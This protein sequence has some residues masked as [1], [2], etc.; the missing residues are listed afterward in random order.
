MPGIQHGAQR[1]VEGETEIVAFVDQQRWMLA[2][3]GVVNA[4]GG[5]AARARRL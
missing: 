1:A 5:D 3:S 2:V 4:G